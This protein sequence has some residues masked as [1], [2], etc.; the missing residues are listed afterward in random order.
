M[1]V[2]RLLLESLAKWRNSKAVVLGVGNVLRGDDGAGPMVC[3]RLAGRSSAVVMDG[4]TAPEN[5][6]R[7]ILRAGPDVLL[8]VDAIDFGGPS[9]QI[10]L[11]EPSETSR[12]AFSTHILSF[13]L[14]AELLQEDRSLDIRLIGIQAGSRRLGE[15]LS[16]AVQDAVET[17]ADTFEALFPV[18]E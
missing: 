16:P 5:Y 1:G 9:G 2:E 3:E 10:R 7:P 17:V 8:I 15:G 14:F 12:F 11:C 13:H 6:I 18:S 4:G